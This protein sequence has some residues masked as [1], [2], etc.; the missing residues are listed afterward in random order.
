MSPHSLA[1]SS[2]SPLPLPSAATAPLL[3][4]VGCTAALPET[5]S[6]QLQTSEMKQRNNMSQTLPETGSQGSWQR[7]FD[8]SS[9][10]GFAAPSSLKEEAETLWMRESAQ[11]GADG[12]NVP[13]GCCAG[14]HPSASSPSTQQALQT[15]QLQQSGRFVQERLLEPG[16]TLPTSAAHISRFHCLDFMLQTCPLTALQYPISPLKGLLLQMLDNR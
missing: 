9:G 6:L 13:Y 4:P 14:G 1:S 2:A 5:G 12:G 7:G 3:Q 11:R 15:L 10:S 8:G 16:K